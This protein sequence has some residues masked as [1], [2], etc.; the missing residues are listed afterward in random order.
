MVQARWQ[1]SD[2]YCRFNFGIYVYY[3]IVWR[4]LSRPSVRPSIHPPLPF[5]HLV[6][7]DR[8]TLPSPPCSLGFPVR[9]TDRPTPRSS[10]A[11]SLAERG[12]ERERMGQ[13]KGGRAG[14]RASIAF[15]NEFGPSALARSVRPADLS[16][17]AC[18]AHTGFSPPPPPP[19]ARTCC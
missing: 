17:A 14:R 8:Q 16:A 19:P 1:W 6:R 12:S 10:G 15:V 7:A 9:P 4:R 18:A 2:A 3:I 5:P 13:K 11:P